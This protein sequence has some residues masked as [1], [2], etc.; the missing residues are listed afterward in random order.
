[1]GPLLFTL[2]AALLG[3]LA[4]WA[5]HWAL[6]HSGSRTLHRAHMTHHR[7]YPPRSLR[8]DAY[9]KAGKDDTLFVLAP[10]VAV[11]IGLYL[12]LM[13]FLQATWLDFAT[14]IT[15]SLV[16]GI[17]HEWLHEAFHLEVHWLSRFAWFQQLR[18][19]HFMHHRHPKKNLGIITM[20]W[21][22]LLGTYRRGG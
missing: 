8:S 3:T 21:D 22:R 4:G 11:V 16:V 15:A 9:R 12:L 18:A 2:G 14:V 13:S 20:L 17:A 19:E 6:H 10:L 7:L 5:G 1:M